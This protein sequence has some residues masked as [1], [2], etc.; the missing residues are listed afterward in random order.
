MTAR[1][2]ILPIGNETVKGISAPISICEYRLKDERA[3][4]SPA[5]RVDVDPGFLRARCRS[6]WRSGARHD[7]TTQ[8]AQN[9]GL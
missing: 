1:G 4:T 7:H 6:G 3:L 8:Y 2:G 9:I 5:R